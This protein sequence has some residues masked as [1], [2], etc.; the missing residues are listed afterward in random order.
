VGDICI[1]E[2]GEI[3][4]V[5]GVFLRGHNVKCDE[6]GATGE[7]DLIKKATYAECIEE[8][9]SLAE[10]KT[11][12]RDCFLISGAK[13]TEG[14]GEYVVIAVGQKSFNGRLMMGECRARACFGKA[15]DPGRGMLT[16]FSFL[17]GDL[18]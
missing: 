7:S 8:R 2:T 15:F 17:F 4:P 11:A 12:K 18:V 16:F 10:G 5:D 6:S 9:N 3:L 1:V 14:V 13:V